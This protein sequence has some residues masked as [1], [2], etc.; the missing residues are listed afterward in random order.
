MADTCG[1]KFSAHA[2]KLVAGHL[3]MHEDDAARWSDDPPTAE[4]SRESEA[5]DD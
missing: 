1:A 2:C 3:G 4:Q 5:W